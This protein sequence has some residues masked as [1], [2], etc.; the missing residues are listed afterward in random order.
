M[1][2]SL[3]IVLGAMVWW[4]IGL[5]LVICIWGGVSVFKESS[6]M[7]GAGLFVAL[8]VNWTGVGSL[9]SMIDFAE[10]LIYV[11]VYILA[12]IGW[13]FYKWR[14]CVE[15]YITYCKSRSYNLEDAKLHISSK[16]NYDTMFYWVMWWPFNLVGYFIND[17]IYDVFMKLIKRLS[18]VY[19]RITDSMLAKSG[20]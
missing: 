2:E 20:F 17:L 5:I 7:L 15:K 6:L 14:L 9:W 8:A 19:D 10:L 18:N 1:V 16:K 3:I 11:G 4:E 12:G 13:S